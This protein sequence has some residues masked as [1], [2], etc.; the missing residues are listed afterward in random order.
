MD[1]QTKLV[2]KI[3]DFVTMKPLELNSHAFAKHNQCIIC[4]QV[5]NSSMD[6]IT[7][8]KAQHSKKVMKKADLKCKMCEFS[9]KLNSN[10]Q[11]H[12]VSHHK[13]CPE[14]EEDF[15]DGET[16]GDVFDH[17]KLMHEIRIYECNICD[18]KAFKFSTLQNHKKE[19]HSKNEDFA[20]EHISI[21]EKTAA[22][23]RKRS[24]S[25][26]FEEEKFG[27]KMDEQKEEENFKCDN[28]DFSTTNSTL[29]QSHQDACEIPIKNDQDV[30]LNCQKCSFSAHSKHEL[31]DHEEFCIPANCQDN[32]DKKDD[33]HQDLKNDG[34]D[35]IPDFSDNEEKKPKSP[36]L[37]KISVK[38]IKSLKPTP[39]PEQFE[40]N[41]CGS[42]YKS[43]FSLKRHK[44]K[45]F[46]RN[47][48]TGNFHCL[49]CNFQSR[50]DS[51]FTSHLHFCKPTSFKCLDCDF[52]ANNESGLKEH[53]KIHGKDEK[54]KRGR[55]ISSHLGEGSENSGNN[56]LSVLSE[57]GETKSESTEKIIPCPIVK[58]T[59]GSLKI[60][61]KVKLDYDAFKE[62][63][64]NATEKNTPSPIAEHTKESRKKRSK[65]KVDNDEAKLDQYLDSIESHDTLNEDP[66]NI[67]VPKLEDFGE[68][69]IGPTPV[70]TD[71]KSL[72][73]EITEKPAKKP[74]LVDILPRDKKELIQKTFQDSPKICQPKQ[75][76]KKSSNFIFACDNCEF[77]TSVAKEFSTHSRQTHANDKLY[78]CDQCHFSTFH[79]QTLIHHIEQENICSIPESS[80]SG[81]R[82]ML[83]CDLCQFEAISPFDIIDHLKKSHIPG[84]ADATSEHDEKYPVIPIPRIN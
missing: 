21:Q 61:K 25:G 36:E 81:G 57:S 13:I 54:P 10:L 30:V 2:C 3:C 49:N 42:M 35:E 69:Y 51:I 34:D 55:R 16:K 64:K 75:K 17:M 68:S 46:K 47:E 74:K 6:L 33:D 70:I 7:H 39:K 5:F 14:C 43:A 19:S 22:V 83:H 8:K 12:T 9:T 76:S 20:K 27:E 65:V 44:K 38:S 40:C 11:F 26:H 72:S 15:S 24:A 82:K 80:L 50:F 41:V 31:E 23:K 29:L 32:V 63:P 71:V 37:P 60:Q 48:T 45:C 67:V 73:P 78:Q 77:T 53:Q 52:L 79:K 28:C 1:V 56:G 58:L 66:D 62:D 4:S 84:D 18:F 59:K